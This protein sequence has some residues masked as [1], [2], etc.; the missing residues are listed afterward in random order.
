MYAREYAKTR[1]YPYALI[2]H[3][4]HEGKIPALKRQKYE[5]DPVEADAVM[6]RIKYEPK[7]PKKKT[8]AQEEKIRSTP[9][10]KPVQK[11]K[12]PYLELLK[13]AL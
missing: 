4:C 12:V 5:I 6:E 1:G 10:S 3:Y 7:G 13:S 9:P 8:E 11:S 2:L